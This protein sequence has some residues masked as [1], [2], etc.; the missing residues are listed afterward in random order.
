MTTQ[1]SASAPA[2]APQPTGGSE[3][4]AQPAP[5]PYVVERGS[6]ASVVWPTA[7]PKQG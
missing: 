7:D 3:S 4:T 6:G 1:Q 2:P 5:A